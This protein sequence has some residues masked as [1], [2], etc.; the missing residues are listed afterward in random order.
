MLHLVPDCDVSVVV[1]FGDDEDSVGTSFTRVAD[2]LRRRGLRFELIAIDED[3]GDNSAMLLSLLAKAM[4]ELRI[5]PVVRLAL[6]RAGA[7]H[8][9]GARVARGR[10]LILLDLS[11]LRTVSGLA[12]ALG[13][14]DHALEL[15][16]MLGAEPIALP[17]LVVA[18]RA[19]TWR[20]LSRGLGTDSLRLGGWVRRALGKGRGS[21]PPTSAAM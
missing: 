6:G 18:R 3:S 7:A 15:A 17:G 11:W 1:P 4:P 10:T 16:P 8:A 19:Q 9:T 21:A 13:E 2:H 12:N 20:A 14:I 5:V